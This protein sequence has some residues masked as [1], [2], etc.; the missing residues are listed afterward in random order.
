MSESQITIIKNCPF[1]GK[2]EGEIVISQRYTNGK[3]EKYFYLKCW[4]CGAELPGDVDPGKAI[5][6]WNRRDGKDG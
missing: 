4:N 6:Q 1:C 2:N 5:E 3:S